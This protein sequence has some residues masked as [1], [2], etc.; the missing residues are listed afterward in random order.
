[1]ELR[2]KTEALPFKVSI[3]VSNTFR[4][5]LQQRQTPEHSRN[6]HARIFD[7]L[8]TVV[9]L[10]VGWGTEELKGRKVEGMDQLELRLKV[11]G[12]YNR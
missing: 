10:G 8:F 11:K 1:M 5:S 12:I 9:H 7:F 2:V 3:S 4:S 6:A